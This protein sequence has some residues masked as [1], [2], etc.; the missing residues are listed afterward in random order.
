VAD[1]LIEV[2][3]TALDEAGDGIAPYGRGRLLVPFTIPGERVRVALPPAS[4]RGGERQT[5]R[6]A[7]ADRRARL[8]A[9]VTPSPHRVAPRCPHFGPAPRAGADGECGGCAW[10][11]IA[12]PEQL[13][14]KTARVEAVVRAALR[15]A[16][17]TAPM[18]PSTPIDA[19]WGYRHKVHFVFGQPSGGRGRGP[20]TMGHYARGSRR[21]V[22]AHACP[23]HADAGN[24]VAFA[25]RD[26]CGRTGVA[27]AG[28]DG[29]NNRPRGRAD[30]TLKSVAVR[31]ARGT[32]EI[33]TT[34]VVTDDRDRGLRTAT[35]AVFDDAPEHVGLHV[36]LHPRPDG[37]IFGRETR[38]LRGP[39]RLREQIGGLS[40]LVSPTAFFQTNLAAAEILVEL[41]RDAIPPGARVLDLY[42]GA[43]LFALPLAA[44]GHAVVAVEENRA[45]TDDGEA[46]RRLNG[47]PSD[48]CR[49]IARP[50]ESA[51][52][53]LPRA[54]SA[55]EA[56]VLDPPRDGCAPEV[57]QAVFAG[58]R[59]DVAVYVSCDPGSLGRDLAAV[60]RLGYTARSVQPV[61]MFPHTPHIETVVV[62]VP[63]PAQAH[64]R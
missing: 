44:A 32:P 1:T 39:A 57:L 5:R 54:A 38:H 47:I 58:Q 36:N 41:V 48:L 22:T 37:Y 33:M 60:D 14:L 28:T 25:L 56:V 34:L 13:R 18:R 2:E 64:F 7:G 11:H 49:F 31:V 35:R 63:R 12:Y 8:V 46:S 62:L 26:A 53:A 21:V 45:A 40:Y 15:D 10:Q 17:A 27:A 24:D 16:P 9:V 51:L 23:V 61:D 30:G 50:V 6:A 52:P 42:A 43:G 29:A 20:L 55:A 59:P 19:P 4:T 3:I